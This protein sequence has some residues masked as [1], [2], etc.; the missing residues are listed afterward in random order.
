[1]VY[2]YSKSLSFL[3]N[4]FAK[5]HPIFWTTSLIFPPISLS[6]EGWNP[7]SIFKAVNLKI[8]DPRFHG[9]DYFFITNLSED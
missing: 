4:S 8:L 3:L 7:V 5:K 2:R 6:S 1:M 9:N